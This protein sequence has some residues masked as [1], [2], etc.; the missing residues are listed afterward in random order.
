MPKDEEDEKEPEERTSLEDVGKGLIILGAVVLLGY[1]ALYFVN[2][3]VL[4]E[5]YTLWTLPNMFAGV[6]MLSIVLFVAGFFLKR[7]GSE[8]E[9]I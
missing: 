2:M 9:D 1:I 7:L 8:D 4:A 6:M 3:T 5:T